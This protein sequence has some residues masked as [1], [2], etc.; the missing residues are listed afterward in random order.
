[1]FRSEVNLARATIDGALRLDSTH[2]D[3]ALN[4]E[5][6]EVAHTLLLGSATCAEVSLEGSKVGRNVEMS[7]MSCSRPLTMAGMRA[8]GALNMRSTVLA[9][10]DLKNAV[11]GGQLNLRGT[12]CSGVLDMEGVHVGSDLLMGDKARYRDVSLLGAKVGG[13]VSLSSCTFGGTLDLEGARIGTDL[14]M[15]APGYFRRPICLLGA[16]IGGQVLMRGIRCRGSVDFEGAHVGGDLLADEASSFDSIDLL[17]ANIG[18]MVDMRQARFHEQLSMNYCSVGSRLRM[19]GVVARRKVSADGTK[20]GSSAIF[21]GALF[22]NGISMLRFETGAQ[23][24]MEKATSRKQT[25]LYGVKCGSW[26]SLKESIFETVDFRAAEVRG[27]V[28]CAGTTV[29]GKFDMELADIGENL[30]LRDKARFRHVYLWDATV[31]GTVDTRAATFDGVLDMIGLHAGYVLLRSSADFRAGVRL[32]FARIDQSLYLAGGQFGHTADLSGATVGGALTLNDPQEKSPTTWRSDSTLILRDA[33]VGKIELAPAPEGNAGMR[34]PRVEL[35]GFSFRSVGQPIQREL[36]KHAALTLPT[37]TEGVV[38]ELLA[39]FANDATS[40]EPYS[41]LAGVLAEHGEQPLANAV[42][43]TGWDRERKNA[44]GLKRAG[45]EM[46]RC[47]IGYG[48]G[49]RYFISLAWVAA[50]TA[51][52]TWVFWDFCLQHWSGPGTAVLFSLDQ[53][54]PIVNMA[55]GAE[56]PAKAVT[57]WP[58]VYLAVHRTAGALLGFFVIAG[59][60]G[61]TERK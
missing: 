59:L 13:Q 35:Q 15:N 60:S 50:F 46:L 3:R 25:N 11:I 31:R 38:K 52:G 4:L 55:P 56:D 14:L 6:I 53:L 9:T 19:D 12:R 26:L 40:R 27:Q 34:C 57:G 18:G 33:A 2:F 22:R 24:K 36:R 20:C 51:L 54:L 28:N 49:V 41:Q 42:R 30:F 10:V 32:T 21:N 45:L 44:R 7:G 61:F 48:I 43:Y 8:R 5:G 37:T 1:M 39:W 16:E 17:D 47:T 23:L 58:R 29:S